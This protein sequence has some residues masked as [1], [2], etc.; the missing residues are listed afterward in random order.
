MHSQERS[1]SFDQKAREVRG[2]GTASQAAEKLGIRI[3]VCL[4]AYRKSLKMGPALAAGVRRFSIKQHFSAACSVVPI[5]PTKMR[6][7]APEVAGSSFL[8][9]ISGSPFLALFARSGRRRTGDGWPGLSRS[10]RRLGHFSR[11]RTKIPALSLHKPERQG[12]GTLVSKIRKKARA[13]PL[14]PGPS[15]LKLE[16][17]LPQTK[18]TARHYRASKISKEGWASPQSSRS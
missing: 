14:C 2:K 9:A 5:R 1:Y 12:Q 15:G 11:R 16:S 4:Q 13:S 10:V 17:N 6:T 8:T 3:R 7:S 18:S